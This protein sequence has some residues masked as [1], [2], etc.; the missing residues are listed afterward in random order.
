MTSALNVLLPFAYTEF[1][2]HRI[3]AACLPRNLASIKLLERAGFEREGFAVA[4]L[5]IA[6]K[7]ED[8]LLWAKLAPEKIR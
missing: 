3:E 4:Y 5:K 6:D 8:H 2:F 7:W 1:D